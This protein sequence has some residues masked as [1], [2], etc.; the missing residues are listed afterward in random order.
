MKVFQCE[1]KPYTKNVNWKKRVEQV[2]E[3][4]GKKH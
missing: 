2:A 4:H 3:E 1:H